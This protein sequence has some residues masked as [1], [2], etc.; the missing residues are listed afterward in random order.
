VNNEELYDLKTDPGETENVIAE[1]PEMV[2]QLRS[3]Y[4]QWWTKVLPRLV[5]EDPYEIPSAK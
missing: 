2:E 5:N 1:Y 3:K 4:H